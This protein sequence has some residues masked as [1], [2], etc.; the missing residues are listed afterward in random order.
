MWDL[1][2]SV[3]DH[4]LSFYFSDIRQEAPTLGHIG[5]PRRATSAAMDHGTRQRRAN[6][7]CQNVFLFAS[8]ESG[9]FW[10][11]VVSAQF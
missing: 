3:P 11:R 8:R 6:D 7:Q 5:V 4:C 9:S 2:V 10:P 1:I